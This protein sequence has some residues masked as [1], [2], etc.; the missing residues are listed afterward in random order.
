VGRR[1]LAIRDDVAVGLTASPGTWPDAVA[2][3][4]ASLHVALPD[5]P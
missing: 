2:T 4:L 3:A 5:P 1:D